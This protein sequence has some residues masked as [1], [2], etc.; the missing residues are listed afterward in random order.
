MAFSNASLILVSNLAIDLNAF[1]HL[2]HHAERNGDVSAAR[3]SVCCSCFACI[4]RLNAS[5]V[6]VYHRSL[7]M[8]SPPFIVPY[9]CFVH[10][11]VVRNKSALTI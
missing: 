8:T 3:E 1:Y 5:I 7:Q 10:C 2:Y 6:R 4:N 11:A 9:P